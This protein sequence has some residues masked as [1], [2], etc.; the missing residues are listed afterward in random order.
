MYFFLI[1]FKNM[2][3][4]KNLFVFD[5]NFKV[6]EKIYENNLAIMK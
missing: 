5:L 1:F 4:L 6:N 2:I 3:T